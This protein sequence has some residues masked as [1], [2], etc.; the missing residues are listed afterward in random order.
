MKIKDKP[1]IAEKSVK[2]SVWAFTGQITQFLLQ[3]GSMILVTRILDPRDYGI[4]AIAVSLNAFASVFN[5]NGLVSA[6]IQ[7]KHISHEEQSIVYLY[8]C[9][10]GLCLTL[11]LFIFSDVIAEFFAVGEL[12]GVI[13]LMSLQMVI[14]ALGSQFYAH[15]I[16]AMNFKVVTLT[17][18][19]ST[20]LGV[21]VTLT[22]AYYG[23]AYWSL[24][25]GYI[26]TSA[27]KLILSISL[28]EWRPKW[29]GLNTSG[30]SL[31]RFGVNVT[32][33]DIVSYFSRNSD[34]LIVG[35]SIGSDQL[36]I[37]S[38]AYQ[39]MMMPISQVR[40]PIQK[41]SFPAMSKLDSSSET[42]KNYY[43]NVIIIISFVSMPLAGLFFLKSDSII[44]LLFGERWIECS[45]VLQVLAIVAFLQPV[46]STRGIVMMS[47]AQTH[48]MMWVRSIQAICDILGFLVGLKW[49]ILG[50]AYGYAISTWLT[51]VPLAWIAYGKTAVK[52]RG[53]IYSCRHAL[54]CA[55]LSIFLMRYIS[56]DDHVLQV[57]LSS[58]IL[59]T[60]MVLLIL[61]TD[62]KKYIISIFN[63][64]KL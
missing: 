38:R 58:C 3:F 61:V 64:I 25:V 35:K 20:L 1:S 12:S 63:I 45:D 24:V 59:L 4:V 7:K 23:Y 33:A 28:T 55:I 32:I 5:G 34:N 18:F 48:K 54:M 8:N 21:I 40:A 36:G 30:S 41:V 14:T 29:Y 60:V 11:M 42:Y 57:L 26:M 16:R 19:L 49:G 56:S 9:L 51:F 46:A 22:M 15:L 47:S 6:V 2:G 62:L 53:V 31:F 50:V 13:R 39:L 43:Y 27:C 10:L 52:V 17:E 37:Y 44:L